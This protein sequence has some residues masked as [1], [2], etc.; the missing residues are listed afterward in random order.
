MTA[1]TDEQIAAA[2]CEKVYRRS[3]KEQPLTDAEIEVS[4]EQLSTSGTQLSFDGGY[5]YN[6]NS[7]FVGRIVQASDGKVFVVFR[8]SDLSGSFLDGIQAM[9]TTPTPPA[10]PTVADP[11]DWND[12]YWLGTGT[13]Q[14][15]H[16]DD[17]LALL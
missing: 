7:G 17:A 12:N 8:G 5:Y 14:R 10:T 11:Y 2:L 9:F 4:S 6:N 3:D 13:F 1:L 16:L 15:T